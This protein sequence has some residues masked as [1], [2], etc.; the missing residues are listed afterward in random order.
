MN[1]AQVDKSHYRFDK[2]Y[3]ID[4]WSSYYYQIKE[5]LSTNPKSVLEIGAGTYIVR[6]TILKSY[7]CSY[8]TIDHDPELKPDK[9]GR[10]DKLPFGDASFDTVCVFQVLEH[11]P[12]NL[13]EKS[14][15]EIH[16]V[17]KD[18]A[19]VSLP[20]FG[21]MISF[22]L[23]IPFLPKFRF[24]I[25]IPYYRKHI[26]NGQHYWEIGKRGYPQR[27]IKNILQKHFEIKDE[28]ILFQNPYHHFYILKK[29]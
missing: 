2:Y 12:F 19:I 23:K 17:S 25:K 8:V 22:S 29:K 11:I 24:A 7:N 27:L 3:S 5:I 9:V 20:H 4:R 26:F 6:D 16:R 15:L 13:F 28:Y 10:I 1:N 14:L 18:N 21:P